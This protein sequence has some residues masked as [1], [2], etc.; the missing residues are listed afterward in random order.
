MRILV[1]SDTHVD[2][3]AQL[4]PGIIAALNGVDLIVH[5]GDFTQ[6]AVL[7]SLRVFA[8]VKAVAGN[9]D[10]LALKLALPE[11]VVFEAGGKKVGVVQ[12]WGGPSGIVGRIRPLFG[13]VDVI[14]YGHSHQPGREVVHGALMFNP[15]AARSSYGI[16]TV[17]K[18][19]KAEIDII[20]EE[21]EQ[22]CRT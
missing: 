9:M 6:K 12:G 21:G 7:D 8:E 15:G 4:R 2:D 20:S 14:I 22:I 11:K 10:S 19:V 5:A 16:L 17:D 1:L 18:E 3:I 13:D